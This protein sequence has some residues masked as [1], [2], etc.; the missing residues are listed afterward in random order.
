MTNFYVLAGLGG[1]LYLNKKTKILKLAIFMLG[2]PY[3][4][5][6][7]FMINM[8]NSGGWF[9]NFGPQST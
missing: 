3:F 8:R 7:L 1:V 4:P 6:K 2:Q 5:T 9:L